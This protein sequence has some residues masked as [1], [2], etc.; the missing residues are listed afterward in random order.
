MFWDTLIIPA[1]VAA[2]SALALTLQIFLRSRLVRGTMVTTS[3]EPS[4]SAVE[5]EILAAREGESTS[6]LSRVALRDEAVILGFD[7]F[8]FLL[9]L[10]LLST[11]TVSAYSSWRDG[12][13]AFLEDA[14]VWL[15]LV[16]CG[17]YVGFVRTT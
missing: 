4:L 10:A 17:I 1:Y 2:A 9:C 16:H 15:Q 12:S 14:T 13:N 8:R 3:L 7:V 11:S 5:N 6:M